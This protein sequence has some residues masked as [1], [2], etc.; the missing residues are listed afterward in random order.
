MWRGEKPFLGTSAS[1]PHVAGA[2]ALLKARFGICSMDQ[3]IE[4]LYGRALDR[5]EAGKDN[6]HG[7]GRLDLVGR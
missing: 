4:V 1:T 7:E 6:Q 3:V 5:G 2:I